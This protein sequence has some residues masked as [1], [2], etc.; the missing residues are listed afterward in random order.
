MRVAPVKV[1]E[2]S[3]DSIY[4]STYGFDSNSGF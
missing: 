2:A 1:K 3:H 4:E